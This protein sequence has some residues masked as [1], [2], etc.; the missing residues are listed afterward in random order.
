MLSIVSGAGLN[1]NG[2]RFPYVG[3][4]DV[5]KP[6]HSWRASE[7]EVDMLRWVRSL[8]ACAAVIDTDLAPKDTPLTA[9]CHAAVDPE[10]R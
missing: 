4:G 9:N 2:N 8:V 5:F 1:I 3:C 7:R 6:Y 10:I